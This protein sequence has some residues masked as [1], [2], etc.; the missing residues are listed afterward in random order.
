MIYSA[1]KVSRRI[2]S[3]CSYLLSFVVPIGERGGGGACRKQQL[4]S[5]ASR[6]VAQKKIRRE[7]Y[8][9]HYEAP[10]ALLCGEMSRVDARPVTGYGTDGLQLYVIVRPVTG[11]LCGCGSHNGNGFRISNW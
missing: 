2:V 4:S 11:L 9:V 5:L 7:N 8:V 6:V 3:V 1:L 10:D